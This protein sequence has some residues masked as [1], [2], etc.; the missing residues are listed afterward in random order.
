MSTDQDHPAGETGILGRIEPKSIDGAEGADRRK[1]TRMYVRKPCKVYHPESQRYLPA[2]THDF[3]VGGAMI[4]LEPG[5]SLRPGD[6]VDVIVGWNAGAVVRQD[7]SIRARV[8]RALE[9]D[10]G[11]QAIAVQFQG[12][13]QGRLA[14]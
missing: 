1:H 10:G 8:L 4:W 3:S 2:S 13:Q 9:M 12:L 11:R 7:A 5:R 14:A 6:D